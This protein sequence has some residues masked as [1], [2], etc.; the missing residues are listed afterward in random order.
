MLTRVDTDFQET[1]IPIKKK[2]LVAFYIPHFENHCFTP[3]LTNTQVIYS[4]MH[5]VG[6]ELKVG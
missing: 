2:T 1:K 5:E 3:S 6:Y 4:E